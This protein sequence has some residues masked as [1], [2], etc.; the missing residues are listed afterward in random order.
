MSIPGLLFPADSV[1]MMIGEIY[2]AKISSD[3]LA[4]VAA[5]NDGENFVVPGHRRDLEGVVYDYMLA[6]WGWGAG[7]CECVECDWTSAGVLM[8]GA[9]VCVRMG[10]LVHV[11]P[12]VCCL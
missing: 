11:L 9:V 6:R 10:V 3:G 1:N 7:V 8:C 2:L 4:D 5:G 12:R